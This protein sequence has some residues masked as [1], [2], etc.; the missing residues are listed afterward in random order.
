[1]NL[2]EPVCPVWLAQ[3]GHSQMRMEGSRL[4]TETCLITFVLKS[5]R[6]FRKPARRIFYA[7]P[8]NPRLT[9]K[10]ECTAPTNIRVKG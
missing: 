6:E 5:V 4:A 1:M 7:E 9:A 3:S 2:G 8:K 10:R